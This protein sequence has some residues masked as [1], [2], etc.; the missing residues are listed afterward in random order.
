[1]G[2]TPGLFALISMLTV[3][4]I[5]GAQPQQVAAHADLLRA[6]PVVDAKLAQPPAQL[7]LSFS[8][9]LKR[10]GSFIQVEE[11]DGSRIP[12]LVSFDDSDAKIMRAAVNG[13]IPGS[14]TVKWQ[15]LSADDDYHDGTYALTVLNADG[16]EPEG[17][18]TSSTTA[19]EDEG[20][21]SGAVIPVAVTAVVAVFVGGLAF[22]IQKSGS[23]AR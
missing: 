5:S 19:E 7:T 13:L 8:Q 23:P 15:T 2:R 11:S 4:F 18:P 17:G 16:S 22:Y 3:L 20:G 14:Y 1:M 10:D 21:G 12:V 9:G 6:E